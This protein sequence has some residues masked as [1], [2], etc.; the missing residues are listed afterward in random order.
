[1]PPRKR[2]RRPRKLANIQ[3]RMDRTLKERAE[4]ILKNI[5]LDPPNAFRMFYSQIVIDH[6]L[7]FRAREDLE[8]GP[9]TWQFPWTK[10]ELD[11]AYQ[12]S[13][14]PKNLSK[15]YHSVDE[16]IRDLKLER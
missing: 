13:L 16:L 2:T 7:P 15:P 12:E 6:G 11:E 9:E 4:R 5:G 14:D 10:E 1:M 3:V 8:A